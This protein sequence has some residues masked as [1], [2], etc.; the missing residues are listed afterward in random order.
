L[1]QGPGGRV[2]N[3]E[4]AAGVAALVVAVIADGTVN[5]A[6]AGDTDVAPG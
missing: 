3:I 4:E 5:L 1:F 6:V 2:P